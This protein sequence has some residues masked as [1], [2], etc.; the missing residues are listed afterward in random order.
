MYKKLFKKSLV[1]S[2]TVLMLFSQLF[3]IAPSIVLANQ[4]SDE[5]KITYKAHVQDKGWMS[6]ETVSSSQS[7]IFVGTTG[8][9]KRMEALEINFVA[10]EGAVLKYRAHVQDKGWMDWVT[11][12]SSEST[13]FAGTTGKSK[14]MEA[15]Q[16]VVEGLEGYEV[17]YRAHVQDKGWMDWVVAG[18]STNGAVT[19]AGTT[20]KSKRMEAL[21]IVVVPKPVSTPQEAEP[22]VMA[23]EIVA[24]EKDNSQELE[25]QKQKLEEENKKKLEEE[26]KK[27]LEEQARKELE[28]QA[29]KEEEERQKLEAEAK[30]K[31]EESK[32][33]AEIVQQENKHTHTYTAW[34]TVTE[35]T[36]RQK[37]L[38]SRECTVCKEVET[39]ETPINLNN[40]SL[41]RAEWLDTKT[42]CTTR[43]QEFSICSRCKQE[44]FHYTEMP[45]GHKWATEKTIDIMPTCSRYGEESIHCLNDGCT[46]RKEITK[47][48]KVAHD[49]EEVE[50]KG[51]C[52]TKGQIISRCKNCDYSK[53][54]RTTSYGDHVYETLNDRVEPTCIRSGREASKQC[55]LCKKIESGSTIKALGHDLVTTTKV[56]DKVGVIV[57]TKCNRCNMESSETHSITYF[58]GGHNWYDDYSGCSDCKQEGDVW[59]W[60][61][62]NGHR[63]NVIWFVGFT[64]DTSKAVGFKNDRGQMVATV[65]EGRRGSENLSSMTITMK[66]P[67]AKEGYEFE[68]WY[69]VSST[70]DKGGTKVTNTSS[71]NYQTYVKGDTIT[72]SFKD[73]DKGFE[74]RYVAK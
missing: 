49:L 65:L 15:I 7:S 70:V 17:K 36:C 10:P 4:E 47:I 35:A 59:W 61:W 34:T 38:E 56:V 20:G 66:A 14:R 32:K 25:E 37:G 43:G 71:S 51:T 19:F 27:Q 60:A 8:K 28:E 46:E 2:L 67:Q 54:V 9:S 3:V 6:W 62:R 13:N 42:T 22:E 33:Q 69:E 11:A 55:K 40:H 41:V 58:N 48:D 21:Q 72:V 26:A 68:G 74:A 23:P 57:E 63:Q 12:D 52:I 24:P 39:R 50:V 45:T 73:M 64:C 29:K 1:I 18:D 53:V 5:P 44:F 31:A 30:A 16:I